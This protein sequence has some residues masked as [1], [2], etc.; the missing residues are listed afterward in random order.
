MYIYVNEKSM[1]KM[2]LPILFF[3][4]LSC[5]KNNT[6][7]AQYNPS[8]NTLS[9]KLVWSDEFNNSGNLDSTKWEFE[10][11]FKRNEEAQWYQKENAICENGNL[12]ITGKRE[13]KPN[14]TFIAG[15]TD[16]R[17]R[18]Q[19]IEFTSAS[20]TMKREHA[21]KYGKIEVRAKIDAQTGLWPAIWTLGVSGEWPSNGEVDIMEYY[22]NKILANFAWASATRWQAI[23]NSKTKSIESLGGAAWASQFHVWTLE[24]DASMM[25]ISIDDVV[26]NTADLS[27]TVNKSDG[28]NPFRQPHYL[29]LNLAMGGNNGGS[30][31]NTVLPSKYLIDYVR[32]YQ[33]K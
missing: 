24:W 31:A 15:S 11:G 8:N 19:F 18:R 13:N 3:T 5:A 4:L 20:V 22:N 23:W 2:L 14:P 27:Q 21:I 29:L 26:I 28:V 12:V 1:K 17:T 10:N 25:K 16:W 32:I 30:L 33:K 7:P 6:T 9:Y